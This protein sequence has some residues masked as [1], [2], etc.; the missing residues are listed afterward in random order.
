MRRR[1][2]TKLFSITIISPSR[3]RNRGAR[4]EARER[5]HN[6]PLLAHACTG[7]RR[8]VG[9]R[10]RKFSPPHARM[11]AGVRRRE[12]ERRGGRNLPLSLMRAHMHM[13]EKE[14]RNMRE[15]RR[16]GRERKRKRGIVSET[17]REREKRERVSL[18]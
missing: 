18:L 3:A 10:G 4:K 9:D 2:A 15:R 7:E 5:G 11:H 13:E 14:R 17:S 8:R 1:E 12:R 16:K 6:S